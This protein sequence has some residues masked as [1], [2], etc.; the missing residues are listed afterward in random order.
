MKKSIILSCVLAL[1]LV[2]TLY[3][4]PK[5]VVNTKAKEVDTEKSQAAT[6]PGASAP[7][8]PASETPSKMH[9]GATL[10]PEQQKNV[11]LLRSGFNQATGKDKIAAGLKLSDTFAK[12]QKFD[13]AASYAEK[14]ARLSPSVENITKAGDRYYEAY[15]F[16]VDDAKAK[17]LGNKTREFYG[18]AIE[19]NPGLLAAKANMAMTYVNTE[20]PMQGILM[21]R[22]VLDTDPTNELALFNLGI[23]SMRSNQYS[24]AADRFRQILTNNPAN[25]KAKFYLGLTLV[26][27]GNKD[28]ARKVLAEVKKEEKDPVIQQA[29][30]EL[31]ERLDN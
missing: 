5:V 3:S 4:L 1:A 24:K 18:K 2:G 15:G 19:K 22:E 8:T 29:L 21:L 30:I 23:L 6:A 14:V 12:L 28:E 27:L 10:S 17:S 7:A 31:Q 25:T 20:N 26:E 11:A 9:D 16:A 13:S